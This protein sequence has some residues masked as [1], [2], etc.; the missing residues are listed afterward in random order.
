MASPWKFLSR[1]VS[2][3]RQPKQE[4]DTVGDAKPDLLAIAAPAETPVEESLNS[5]GGPAVTELPPPD[6]PNA[7]PA[8]PAPLREAE[9][10]VNDPPDGVGGDVVAIGGT[11][12]S[13]DTDIVVTPDAATLQLSVDDTKRKQR[14]RVKKTKTAVVISQVPPVAHAASDDTMSL[15]EEIRVLRGQLA[16]KLQMQN[17]QLKKM[18]ERFER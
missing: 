17:A 1:L 12:L 11:A 9:S 4:G 16:I 8:E 18:L 15:D 3:R 2:P 10:E 6:S 14:G 5:A 13:D 7:V